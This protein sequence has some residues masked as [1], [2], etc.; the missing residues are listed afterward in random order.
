M[1]LGIRLVHGDKIL[2]NNTSLLANDLLITYYRDDEK[3]FQNHLNFALHLHQYLGSLYG[4]H[5]LL[6]SINTLA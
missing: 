3:Y 2:G 6:S 1:V 4:Q 5:G